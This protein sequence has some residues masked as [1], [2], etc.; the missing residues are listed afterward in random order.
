MNS[1]INTYLRLNIVCCEVN[2]S[3]KCLLIELAISIN[4]RL[5]PNFQNIIFLNLSLC[6][7]N[8]QR[9]FCNRKPYIKLSGIPTEVK[10]SWLQVKLGWASEK[11]TFSLYSMQ[12]KFVM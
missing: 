8:S 4:Q 7:V 6:A 3:P 11:F 1:T 5:E 2:F 12:R 9:L 10:Q